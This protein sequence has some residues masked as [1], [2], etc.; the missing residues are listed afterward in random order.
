MT[1]E[2]IKQ[3]AKACG[4]L[5]KNDLNIKV[6]ELKNKGVPFLGCIAFIQANQNLS[7]SEA[8]DFILTLECWTEE[9][10]R[11]IDIMLSEFEET[12]D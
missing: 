4:L 6:L 12:D 1:I 8:K 3:E 10:R 7:L 9:G 5:N 2:D 11:S